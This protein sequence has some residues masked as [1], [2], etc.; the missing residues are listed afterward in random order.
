MLLTVKIENTIAATRNL[1]SKEGFTIAGGKLISANGKQAVKIM[2]G[3]MR[4]RKG[5]ECFATLLHDLTESE[6]DLVAK[7]LAVDQY[8]WSIVSTDDVSKAYSSQFAFAHKLLLSKDG[9]ADK[10]LYNIGTFSQRVRSC[11]TPDPSYSGRIDDMP[12]DCAVRAWA[13]FENF[14]CDIPAF[15]SHVQ[16]LRVRSNVVVRRCNDDD[17]LTFFRFLTWETEARCYV[18]KVYHNGSTIDMNGFREWFDTDCDKVVYFREHNHL[19]DSDESGGVGFHKLGSHINVHPEFDVDMSMVERVPYLD[20]FRYFDTIRGDATFTCEPNDD[21]C[22]SADSCSGY[23]NEYHFTTAMACGCCGDRY[24]E[25][26]MLSTGLDQVSDSGYVCEHCYC[27]QVACC[28][29]CGEEIAIQH[30]TYVTID[31]THRTYGECCSTV[32]NN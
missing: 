14:E 9:D 3:L 4:L 2:R 26:E 15:Y 30:E 32:E 16:G 27:E 8:S 10:T 21:S 17:G 11:M 20:S 7:G 31:Q 13:T 19:V 12:M 18:D 1:L 24:P 23:W 5:R 29:G 6:I 28:D 25:E 22:Y